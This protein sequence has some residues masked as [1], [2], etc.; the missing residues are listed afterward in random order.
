MKKNPLTF[1]W[2]ELAMANQ[3][4]NFVHAQVCKEDIEKRRLK[5]VSRRKKK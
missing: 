2:L 1:T 3:W 4:I 5:R